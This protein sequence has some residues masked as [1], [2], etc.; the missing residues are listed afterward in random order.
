MFSPFH[1]PK[2]DALLAKIKANELP[3][4]YK[5]FNGLWYLFFFASVTVFSIAVVYFLSDLP[6]F[7]KIPVEG[8][9]F[10]IFFPL[11][12]AGLYFIGRKVKKLNQ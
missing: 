8:L 2:R 1:D 4:G 11:V 3:G 12:F 10:V 5:D 7:R 9:F 6:A